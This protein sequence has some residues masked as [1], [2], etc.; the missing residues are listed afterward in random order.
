[1][2]RCNDS[3]L[4]GH[5]DSNFIPIERLYKQENMMK[6][7]FLC[8]LIQKIKTQTESKEELETFT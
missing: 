7:R 2:K 8:G 4:K 5:N 1:M 3:L 6:G